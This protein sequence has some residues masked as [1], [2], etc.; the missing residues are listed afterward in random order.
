[1]LNKQCPTGSIS[2]RAPSDNNGNLNFIREAPRV[3][4]FPPRHADAD[5]APYT[6]QKPCTKKQS[7][8]CTSSTRGSMFDS[9]LSPS[10][11]GYPHLPPAF[12]EPQGLPAR[13]PTGPSEALAP[14]PSEAEISNGA[15]E[16]TTKILPSDT[17]HLQSSLSIVLVNRVGFGW[18]AF[19]LGHWFT[20]IV[21]AKQRGRQ[22]FWRSKYII[23]INVCWRRWHIRWGTFSF[24]HL[25]AKR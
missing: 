24:S 25:L 22:V 20:L 15:R 9:D 3:P 17:N 12:C 5:K 10:P 8:I 18:N 4:S 13:H 23:T 19:C 6:L 2:G 16:Q 7:Q 21:P 14:W 1:M 11:A